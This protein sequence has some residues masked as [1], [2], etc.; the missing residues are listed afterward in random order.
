MSLNHLAFII[1]VLLAILWFGLLVTEKWEL[2]QIGQ[3]LNRFDQPG[4]RWQGV[5]KEVFGQ[6]RVLQERFSGMMHVMMFWGF[7][8]Y[9]SKR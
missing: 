2:V 3:P 1:V 5:W 9:Q 6:H 7:L 4:I 8:L